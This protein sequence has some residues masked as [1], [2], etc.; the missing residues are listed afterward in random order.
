MR[1][2]IFLASMVACLVAFSIQDRSIM[3]ECRLAGSQGFCELKVYG[4]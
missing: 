1:L 2:P 4:R 3:R